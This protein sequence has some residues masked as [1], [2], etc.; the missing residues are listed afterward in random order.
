MA[1]NIP[2]FLPLS[3][4][5]GTFLGTIGT[6]GHILE[7][8]PGIVNQL[9]P[10][11]NSLHFT[12]FGDRASFNTA[13]DD[14]FRNLS[15]GGIAFSSNSS[16]ES[17]LLAWEASSPGLAGATLVNLVSN[18]LW[19]SYGLS[20]GNSSRVLSANYQAFP[21]VSGSSLNALKWIGF[22]GATMVIYP[23]FRD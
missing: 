22:F 7:T 2:L 8:P 10:I 13:I 5:Y 12:D 23:D 20:N 14:R 19:K 11:T 15:L 18:V 1:T 4:L 3:P 6:N 16:T 17:A 21:T 9:G